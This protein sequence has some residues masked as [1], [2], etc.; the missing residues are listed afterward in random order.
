MRTRN[1]SAILVSLALCA[2]APARAGIIET[3]TMLTGALQGDPAA[4]FS[5]DFQLNDGSGT[6][7][8]N[9]TAVLS[10]F[11]FG[12]GGGPVGSAALSG[13]ATGDL[14]S[15]VQITDSGFLN[16]FTQGFTP[17]TQLQFQLSLT[18][19]VDA[20]GTPDQF[21]MAILDSSGAQ[22]PTLSFF[23]VFVEIDLDSA[24]PAIQTFASDP[25][26]STVAGGAPIDLSAPGLTSVSSVPEP[27]SIFLLGCALA[28]MVLRYITRAA[29]IHP[30][31]SLAS[32]PASGVLV[33]THMSSGTNKPKFFVRRET[34]NWRC[35]RICS[36]A[37]DT[38]SRSRR[39]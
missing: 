27:G 31:I 6:G 19:N 37:G 38:L 11:L 17:G 39:G 25:S 5:L 24:N 18:T 3:F 20:G 23:D 34:L 32:P 35:A 12:T 30:P 33:T 14:G 21:S 7:D 10:N 29:R 26:R 22:L 9:N 28:V 15:S 16:E 8:G 2:A 4:P 36:K 1:L 13:G